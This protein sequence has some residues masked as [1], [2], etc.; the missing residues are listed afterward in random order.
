ELTTV[1]VTGL[2]AG[3]AATIEPAQGT[4][5]FAADLTLRPSPDVLG[6]GECP[7]GQGCYG[8]TVTANSSSSHA[9]ATSTL[10]V[11]GPGF[12]F[13]QASASPSVVTP[14]DTTT[15]T[16]RWK[17]NRVCAESCI[18]KAD[19]NSSWDRERQLAVLYDGLD[20]AQGYGS[21]ITKQFQVQIPLEL[22]AGQHHV[23][24]GFPYDSRFYSYDEKGALVSNGSASDIE[25]MVTPP[26][27]FSWI[28]LKDPSS[29]YATNPVIPYVAPSG[30]KYL[31]VLSGSSG[32]DS[33]MRGAVVNGAVA[34][35]ET[36]TQTRCPAF[37]S[38]DYGVISAFDAQTATVYIVGG[39]NGFDNALTS[40]CSARIGTDGDIGSWREETRLNGKR[41]GHAVAVH[42]GRIYA[43]SGVESNN[44]F[45]NTVE[46]ATIGSDG[47]LSAWTVTSPTVNNR[48]E[49]GLM[50]LS[51]GGQSYLYALGGGRHGTIHD[52]IERAPIQAGGVLGAW[53]VISVKLSVTR[54]LPGIAV[55]GGYVYVIGGHTGT[56]GAG[57]TETVER[58]L[59]TGDGL[60]PF[61][62][63]DNLSKPRNGAAVGVLDGIIYAV[64]AGGDDSAEYARPIAVSVPRVDNF[65]DGIIDPEMWVLNDGT[66][67]SLDEVG[68]A[69]FFETGSSN[70]IQLRTRHNLADLENFELL[71]DIK[72]D[73]VSGDK[74][75]GFWLG[76]LA[77]GE[78]SGAH[79][80][81]QFQFHGK[82]SGF[83]IVA[84]NLTASQGL[85]DKY[86]PPTWSP[87]Q[88]HEVK[89]TR[90][91][92]V[93]RFYLNGELVGADTTF[94]SSMR[95]LYWVTGRTWNEGRGG[96]AARIHVDNFEVR[97]LVNADF[98][99]GLDGWERGQYQCGS[100]DDIAVLDQAGTRAQSLE[101]NSR[102]NGGCFSEVSVAQ[103]ID[104]DIRSA[105]SVK[106]MADVMSIDSTVILG[107]GNK[108]TETPIQIRLT[109][110]TA[111]EQEKTVDWIF[112]HLTSSTCGNP[113]EFENPI[114]V[115][116]SQSVW[117]EFTSDNLKGIDSSAAR[118]IKIRIAGRGWDYQGRAD[119]VRIVVEEKKLS[120]TENGE[121][122]E[123]GAHP[124]GWDI[125]EGG[126]SGTIAVSKSVKK[127]GEASIAVTRDNYICK[128]LPNEFVGKVSLSVWMFP[129]PDNNTNNSIL[130]RH[131]DD[132][133]G[134]IGIHVNESHR[135]WFRGSVIA[136][137]SETWTLVQMLI[138]T[139]T[140]KLNIWLDGVM[141]VSDATVDVPQGLSR[142]CFLSGR[143]ASGHTSYFDELVMMSGVSPE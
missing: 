67:G 37:S 63:W 53:D 23:R 1:E 9:E 122:Y 47:T 79:V 103:S 62:Q 132:I 134:S 114:A 15:I 39:I 49:A 100:V 42:D 5:P 117:F 44:G 40:V 19:A 130:V 38:G 16:V 119:N 27:S 136:N 57:H 7:D 96:E 133:G 2:P 11:S 127:V 129:T 30:E 116:V 89:V 46:F 32:G 109:Y 87:G 88:W 78:P 82:T 118:I 84:R 74:N 3:V 61:E 69:L 91:N 45:I 12:E 35:W 112:S 123:D 8:F 14:G 107:C 95:N 51:H 139:I 28:P 70:D 142:V 108:G 60:D 102:G 10:H 20:N 50:I 55:T 99:V 41:F 106:V 18:V 4:P 135:W 73:W 143:G 126:E 120:F 29:S 58:A 137:Y 22:S 104:L 97:T 92:G 17:F 26:A 105:S 33:Y 110:M 48:H 81:Y 85:H 94:A 140:G 80:G 59:I 124:D 71:F 66:G 121:G 77:E 36:V 34:S 72:P 83:N 101:F 31:Y 115:A 76:N 111:T 54:A 13:I 24:V 75:V 98:L 65:D 141:V 43:V 52:S 68:G 113:Q 64:N 21:E 25:I 125:F 86:D 56:F 93:M 6:G 131:K 128:N 138:N 90:I